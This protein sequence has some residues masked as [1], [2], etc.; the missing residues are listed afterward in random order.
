MV[1]DPRAFAEW[2]PETGKAGLKVSQDHEY[3]EGHAGEEQFPPGCAGKQEENGVVCQG[4][5]V[6][7]SAGAS[8]RKLDNVTG[9]MALLCTIQL[10]KFHTPFSFYIN[11]INSNAKLYLY[12]IATL[13]NEINKAYGRSDR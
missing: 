8:G 13:S 7:E 5:N 12:V 9:K 11:F 2:H 3:C 10:H 1:S 6:K 4:V